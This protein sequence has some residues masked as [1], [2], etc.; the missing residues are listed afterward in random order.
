MDIKSAHIR[1]WEILSLRILQQCRMPM[2]TA[3]MSDS[4]LISSDRYNCKNLKC[5]LEQVS[6]MIWLII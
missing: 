5:F 6:V 1:L 2:K 3:G 4:T